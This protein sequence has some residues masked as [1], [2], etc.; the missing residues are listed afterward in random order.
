MPAK[1]ARHFIEITGVRCERVQEISDEDCIKEGIVEF[2]GYHVVDC[3]HDYDYCYNCGGTGLCNGLGAGLGVIYDCECS[4]C[5]DRGKY[6][7]DCK[8]F[9][10]VKD[11]PQQAYAA[12]FDKI[13]RKGSFE[14]NPYVFCYSFKLTK[15]Q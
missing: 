1:Y 15:N 9:T 13:N 2:D 6:G 10:I 4:Y 5:K 14:R 11:T 3:G 12:L 7:I 8:K